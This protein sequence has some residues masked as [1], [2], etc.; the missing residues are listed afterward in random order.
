M[1]TPR[2]LVR[3]DELLDESVRVVTGTIA[4]LGT[5]T[6]RVRKDEAKT[7][8]ERDTAARHGDLAKHEDLAKHDDL[9][10][11]D[12]AGKHDQATVEDADQALSSVE[13]SVAE[14]QHMVAEL[15]EVEKARHTLRLAAVA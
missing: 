11:G 3:L 5:R 6:M 15:L 8:G 12:D 7:D 9:A 1:T 13:A 14:L 10:K 2:E 4:D